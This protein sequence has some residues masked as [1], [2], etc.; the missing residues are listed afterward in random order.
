MNRNLW[1]RSGRWAFGL[2]AGAA[3]TTSAWSQEPP[4]PLPKPSP[5]A[6]PDPFKAPAQETPAKVR[7]E[8][9]GTVQD[10]R[11]GVRNTTGAAR[12]TVQD[13]R[14]DARETIRDARRDARQNL[15]AADLGL[16]FGNRA[17]TTGLVI[18]DV[19]GQGYISKAG[20]MEG[21]R[22]VSVN[23]T[24]VT[25]DAEFTRLLTDES[26]RNQP[27]KVVVMRADK[28]ET[29]TVQPAMLMK[30]VAEHDPLWQYGIVLDDRYKD[31]A[32]VQRVFPRTPAYYA[33]LRAGDTVIG[34]RGQRIAAIA[35]LARALAQNADRIAVEINRGNQT[36]DLQIESHTNFGGD[37]QTTLKPQLD[38][39]GRP[40][41]TPADQLPKIEAPPIRPATPVIPPRPT[42][43]AIPAPRVPTPATPAIP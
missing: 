7:E 3:L 37:V 32:V 24:P 42:T 26:V 28:E 8:A 13:A 31:R 36:R 27:V 18:A 9:R 15:R 4:V 17:G 34:V 19:G 12:E 40:L 39:A 22:I 25:T 10:A 2:V 43:P 6:A 5:V 29:L 11:E 14:R 35:D 38:A 1:N 20:F 41:P 21:D 23:G 16:W 33:G 30:E